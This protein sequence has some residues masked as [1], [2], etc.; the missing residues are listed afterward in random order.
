MSKDKFRDLND[1]DLVLSQMLVNILI[2]EEIH[3]NRLNM[4]SIYQLF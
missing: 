4:A 1:V 2:Y 3:R